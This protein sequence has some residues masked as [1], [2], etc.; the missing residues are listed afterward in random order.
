MRKPENLFPLPLLLSLITDALK[1]QNHNDRPKKQ[2]PD[3]TIYALA[4]QEKNTSAVAALIDRAINR[5]L[6]NNRGINQ[7][8]KLPIVF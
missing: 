1:V 7:M 2:K 3:E 8:T 4:A 6:R 5:R